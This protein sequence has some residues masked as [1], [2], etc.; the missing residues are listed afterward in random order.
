MHTKKEGMQVLSPAPVEER[1]A[2][3][4]GSQQ[5]PLHVR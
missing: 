4:N 5:Q 1:I 3:A 2:E